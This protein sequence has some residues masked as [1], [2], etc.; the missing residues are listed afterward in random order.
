M[1]KSLF[2]KIMISLLVLAALVLVSVSVYMVYHPESDAVKRQN[3]EES[4]AD[5]YLESVYRETS[6]SGE[7]TEETNSE[8]TFGENGISGDAE[9]SGEVELPSA[10]A[11]FTDENYY[12]RDGKTYTPDYA[13]GIMLGVLEIEPCKI[14][15]GVYSGTWEDIQHDLDIWMVT[16]ARP[17][18][19][20]G[21]THMAIY[22]HNHPTQDLSFNRLKELQ[23]GDVFTF[24]VNNLVYVYDVA[25]FIADW[26]DI[27]T[28]DIVD[29][30][31]LPATDLYVITCGRGEYACKDIVY[32]G[33]LRGKVN[34][35]AYAENPDH[36]KYDADAFDMEDE[37]EIED[38]DEGNADITR[39]TET[40]LSV[41][42]ND[43][44]EIVLSCMDANDTPVTCE[45]GIY[46]MDGLPVCKVQ[47][48]DNEIAEMDL[49][50]GVTYIAGIVELDTEVYERPADVV[51]KYRRGEIRE[52]EI[53]EEDT[54][55]DGLPVY[56]KPLIFGLAAVILILVIL[57]LMPQR[58]A[59]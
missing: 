40:K 3:T 33:R 30:F 34:I 6:A 51:F 7:G 17:D 41:M 13:Q 27:V 58:K 10:T 46:D 1:N 54:D 35:R 52:S 15:R 25:E 14:R 8:E 12:S 31:E 32:R 59:K 45:I 57:I 16:A 39:K 23:V 29:N 43:H 19:V 49:E 11:A 18:Y 2:R 38:P 22:G 37:A 48:P 42:L 26:R 5:A 9:A 20:L 50:D 24:T 4:L 53:I 36:Y 28:R 44:K 21:E 56:V 47:Y 55:A